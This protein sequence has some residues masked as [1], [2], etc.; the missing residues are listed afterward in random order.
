MRLLID[1][2]QLMSVFAVYNVAI[3]PMQVLA[4]VAGLI[5][6]YFAFKQTRYSNQIASGLLSLLWLWTGLVF[7]ILYW[8][9]IYR[10]ANAFGILF[11]A[12][13][14]LL[15]LQ[16]FKPSLSFK[17]QPNR[18]TL[19]GVLFIVYAM[20]MYPLIG[21]FLG[22]VY[23]RSVPF[24][25]VPCPTTVFTIG[26]LMMTNKKVPPHLLA[27]PGIWSVCAVVPVLSGV[28][29]DVGLILAGLVCLPLLLRR[30]RPKGETASVR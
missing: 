25:L 30:E 22:R 29:E 8:A 14:L 10:P 17:A 18:F 11:I 27:I 28:Y 7:C 26:L 3:W 9:P 19:I 4:Y 15:L 12:Q 13:G 24:G 16:S 5:A 6:F 20:I 2:E 21:Y 23:P 1:L